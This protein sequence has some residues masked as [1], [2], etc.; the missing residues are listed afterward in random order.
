MAEETKKSEQKQEKKP[1]KK[2]EEK[3]KSIMISKEA[4]TGRIIRIF[5]TD[6][7]GNKNL[8]C[9]LTRIKGVSWAISNAVCYLNKLDKTRKVESLSKEEI[10]KLEETLKGHKFPKY[11]L[12]RRN[13]FNTGEDSHLIGNA[14]E[15]AE[16]LDIK[17]LK[18]IRSWRGWRHAFGQPTRGQSTKAHFRT[19]RKRGVGMKKAK[20]V[21][22]NK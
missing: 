3:K 10:Q 1:E 8:Y 11:M 21:V 4:P 18:K 15:L 9:G 12:N 20:P 19:N 2:T 16:E 7:P 22:V 13:D 5:Q 6:V 17:R 14:L